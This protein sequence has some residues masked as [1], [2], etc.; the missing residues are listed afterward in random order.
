MNY[1]AMQQVAPATTP[2]EAGNALSAAMNM[3]T[4]E[5]AFPFAFDQQALA[6]AFSEEPQGQPTVPPEAPA[7][8][9]GQLY[10]AQ[11]VPP[12]NAD[13]PIPPGGTALRTRELQAQEE[14]PPRGGGE[15]PPGG[16][17]ISSFFDVFVELS[18]PGRA[19]DEPGTAADEPAPG[20]QI[21]TE[22][23]QLQLAGQARPFE[24]TNPGGQ[25]TQGPPRVQQNPVPP[26]R[27]NIGSFF[28]IFTE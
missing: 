6:G 2:E 17:R 16:N 24:E 23:V 12:E 14:P 27:G 26:P 8:Y 20:L 10:R 9:P 13:N 18:P 7:P 15:T 22:M 21:D 5:A 3:M 19:Q 1:R 28:D 4:Q 25:A 11:E